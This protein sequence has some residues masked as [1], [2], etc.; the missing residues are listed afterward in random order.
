MNESIIISEEVKQ[1]FTAYATLTALGV[2]VTQLEMF[3]PIAQQV[4]IAQKTVK[5]TPIE[6][7]IDA[8][9]AILAG[10]HGMVEINKR[11]RPDKGLQ[12]AFGREGCAEQSVVQDTLDA[13]SMA[14]VKQMQTALDQ[15]Y[16]QHSQGYGH[17]YQKDWQLLDVD[18]TGRPCGKK[19]AFATKGYFAK[20]RNRRGRQEG[21]LIATHYDEIVTKQLFDGKTQL[22][23]GLRPLVLA[24]EKTLGLD[25]DKEK[26]Q[27]TILRVDAGG[28]SVKDVNWVLQRGYQLHGKDY[29]GK[30]AQH[31]A[32]SVVEWFED[33]HSPERQV[34]WVTTADDGYCHPLQRIAVRCRK[35]N[36]QW[37]VGVIL[38]TLSPQQVLK[39]TGQAV[40]KANDPRAVLLAYVYFYDQRGGGVETEIKEDKQGLGTRKRNKKRFPAQAML[41]RLETLAHNLLVWARRWLAPLCPKVAQFGMLRL[42]RDAFHMNGLIVMDPNAHILKI[43]FNQ[44]DPLA[45]EMQIGFA[46]LFAQQHL[47]VTLGEI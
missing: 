30:R 44:V 42:V 13:C 18:M 47:A 36:G 2:K 10:A 6:K 28:G 8:E 11:V 4:K 7:L 5:Y 34:G 24:A 9:I 12:V 26:R 32:E 17:D 40:V 37:G 21:Y 31:L 39:L 25:Q 33:P 15:I 43:I 23:K 46:A 38:S 27:R 35:H 29:S 19:A 22:T 16:R 14:N 1:H 41:T 3:K 45:K 20:Q